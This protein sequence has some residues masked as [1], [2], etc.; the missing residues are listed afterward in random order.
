MSDGHWTKEEFIRRLYDV[1]PE[2]GHPDSCGRCRAE[3]ESLLDRRNRVLSADAP[4][5]QDFL[6]RQRRAI[7]ARLGEPR[8][9]F[10]VRLLPA[11]SAV[12]LILVAMTVFRPLPREM[13][14]DVS[15]DTQLYQEAVT[16]ASGTAPSAMEPLQSLFEV[17]Q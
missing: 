1:G 2:D 4:V 10:R 3:W 11:M 15:Q 9:G 17:D 13:A 6:L 12:L 8:P 14:T 5:S 7:L 16:L